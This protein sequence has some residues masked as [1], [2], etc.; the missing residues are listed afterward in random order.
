LAKTSRQDEI[1]I[2]AKS[3]S[4][5]LILARCF[6]GLL[7]Q[8]AP[9]LSSARVNFGDKAILNSYRFNLFHKVIFTSEKENDNIG[10]Y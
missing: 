7:L 3:F 2:T 4:N 1:G 5:R 10:I 8:R 6:S 9:Y